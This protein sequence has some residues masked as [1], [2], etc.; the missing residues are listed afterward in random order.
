M[1]PF[2]SDFNDLLA[3]P[4]PIAHLVTQE[5]YNVNLEENMESAV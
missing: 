1:I 4:R 3:M 5:K 2:K